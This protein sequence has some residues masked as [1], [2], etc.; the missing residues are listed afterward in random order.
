MPFKHSCFIS[1]R[2]SKTALGTENYKKFIDDLIE[3]ICDYRDEVPYYDQLYAEPGTILPNH[4]A[5][6]ICYSACMNVIFTPTYTKGE[7]IYCAREYTAMKR[8]ERDRIGLRDDLP[9][10]E[11]G[12]IIPI[13]TRTTELH[14]DM[15]P[16]KAIDCAPHILNSG[17]RRNNNYR[18][19]LDKIAQRVNKI[20]VHFEQQDDDPVGNCD[21]FTFPNIDDEDVQQFIT[22]GVTPIPKW[23]R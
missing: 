7:Q 22:N 20:I 4:L 21:T 14:P 23:V 18:A 5:K 19:E 11:M 16:R 13:I 9:D 17:R 12:L 1:Y 3:H 6:A 15:K 2:H 8:L 10:D